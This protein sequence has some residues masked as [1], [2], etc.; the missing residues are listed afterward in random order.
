MVGLAE[1]DAACPVNWD[2]PGNA[3]LFFWA[4]GLPGLASPRGWADLTG[5]GTGLA[6][7]NATQLGRFVGGGGA[8]PDP[9]PR[10]EL[11]GFDPV[12][13]TYGMTG[14][15]AGPVT[16]GVAWAVETFI[17]TLPTNGIIVRAAGGGGGGYAFGV[18]SGTLDSSGSD[19]IYLREGIGW[20]ALGVAA[21][22]GWGRFLLAFTTAGTPRFYRNGVLLTTNANVPSGLTGSTGL[23]SVGGYN[24]VSR[25]LVGGVTKECRG[26]IPPGAWDNTAIDA[27]AEQDYRWSRRAGGDPRLAY[28]RSYTALV[29]A[30]LASIPPSVMTVTNESG[31]GQSYG[32]PVPMILE[33]GTGSAADIVPNV[34]LD[35][36]T[37]AD[38]DAAGGGDF[39]TLA[40]PP[41]LTVATEVGVLQSA[42]ASPPTLVALAT[43]TAVAQSTVAVERLAA[44]TDT[45]VRG[46]VVMVQD[47]R[48]D[49]LATARYRR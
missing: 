24:G 8:N 14:P 44:A 4:A 49:L 20:S 47:G 33:T 43:S 28:R 27:Y 30:S 36:Q 19:Y 48:R 32:I 15:Y 25:S 34:P 39:P 23:V 38:L 35:L 2:H 26:V 46:S 29:A 10:P 17:P 41:D 1:V 12:T 9:G 45:G 11:M 31:S 5:R 6:P 16:A 40:L 18:G 42:I 22:A 3:G 37:W 21:T 13:Q 7:V